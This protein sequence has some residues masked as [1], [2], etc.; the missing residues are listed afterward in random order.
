MYTV[1]KVPFYYLLNHNEIY[2]VVFKNNYEIQKERKRSVMSLKLNIFKPYK[3]KHCIILR[4]I[5]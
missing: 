5:V 1:D 3:R 2:L 4:Y